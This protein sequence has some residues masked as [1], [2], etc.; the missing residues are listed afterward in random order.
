MQFHLLDTS[1]G[2]MKQSRERYRRIHEQDAGM[3]SLVDLYKHARFSQCT[4]VRE[5]GCQLGMCTFSC[6]TVRS[7]LVMLESEPSENSDVRWPGTTP[8][9]LCK[10]THSY[11]WLQPHNSMILN[12][13]TVRHNSISWLGLKPSSIQNT[14]FSGRIF[15][16]LRLISP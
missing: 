11:G 1:W 14:L 7:W 9:G 5:K 4:V 13:L 10:H 15:Q 6:T 12:S 8:W 3:W 2:E 16:G